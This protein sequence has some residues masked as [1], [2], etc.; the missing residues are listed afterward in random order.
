MNGARKYVVSN[1]LTDADVG[2]LLGRSPAT[3]PPS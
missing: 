3:S 2:E 1:T